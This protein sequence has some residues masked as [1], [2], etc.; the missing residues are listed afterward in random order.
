MEQ[1]PIQRAEAAAEALAA[2]G[3]AVTGRS[4]RAAA[5]VKMT[6]AV[7]A[8]RAWNEREAREGQ[9]PD[10]PPA[11]V[12]RATGMWREAYTLARD[13]FVAERTGWEGR[14]EALEQDAAQL[15]ADLDDM[16][17]QRDAAQA[18]ADAATQQ[19]DALRS[20]LTRSEAQLEDRQ[21]EAD[22]LREEVRELR[23]RLDQERTRAD[24]AE[25]RAEALAE[26]HQ[27][28]DTTGKMNTT[29]SEKDA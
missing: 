7:D 22:R 28:A 4:V 6:V 21:A 26:L 19:A 23:A 1:T 16:E 29:T 15:T 11:A 24:R 3:E 9:I 12:A 25:A 8:A 27:T 20:R 5:G 18:M 13:L 2:A 17:T 14:I 10:M